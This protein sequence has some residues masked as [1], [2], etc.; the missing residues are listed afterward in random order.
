[1]TKI[2]GNKINRIYFRERVNNKYERYI[3]GRL[4]IAEGVV[5]SA[6]NRNHDEFIKIEAT[7]S[8]F[9]IVHYIYI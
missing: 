9:Q 2:K 6:E 7:L 8:G 5:N 3:L 1:M 4:Y